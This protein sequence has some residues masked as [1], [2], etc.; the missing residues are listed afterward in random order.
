[1][2]RINQ[3]SWDLGKLFQL[4]KLPWKNVKLEKKISRGHPRSVPWRELYVTLNHIIMHGASIISYV[5]ASITTKG[6]EAHGLR[7]LICDE[8]R[9]RPDMT[10]RN[11]SQVKGDLGQG[12]EIFRICVKLINMRALSFI[13]IER[14]WRKLFAKK[15]GGSI[16]PPLHVRG[17]TLS[18]TWGWMQPPRSFLAL[19]ATF[20]TLE[21]W[22]SY[23]CM[24]NLL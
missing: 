9:L 23:N 18:C 21:I 5:A 14:F 1:M 2:Q 8:S 12:H 22:F 17:L 13:T 24:F 3:M 19:H 20:L 4:Q 7:A 6:L 11:M 16:R 10:S 15:R